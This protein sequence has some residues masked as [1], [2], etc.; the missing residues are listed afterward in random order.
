MQL[1]QQA[2]QLITGKGVIHETS[3]VFQSRRT[4]PKHRSWTTL[5]V[6]AAA[7]LS[8]TH[9]TAAQLIGTDICGC[10]PVTYTFTFDFGLTCDDGTISGPGINETACLTEV[11]GEAEVPEEDKVPVTVQS[12][13]IF[14]LDENKQVFSQTVR[15]GTFLDGSNFTYTSIISTISDL[16]DPEQ[17]PRGLQL[18][19]TG[20]NNKEESTVQTYIITYTN[21]CG[22]FPILTE[23]QRYGWTIFVRFHVCFFLRH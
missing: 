20:L 16:E 15:T 11:R 2:R 4:A 3:V 1:L 12:I 17:L 9:F 6:T 18:V 23:G 13:Q 14:E 7:L 19:I 8:S 10:Q 21:D 22:I 5:V